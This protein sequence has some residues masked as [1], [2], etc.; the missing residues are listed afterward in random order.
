[1]SLQERAPDKE[2]AASFK[3]NYYAESTARGQWSKG[4]FG[5]DLD[6]SIV[7]GVPR[8]SG[9]KEKILRQQKGNLKAVPPTNAAS[10]Q[11]GSRLTFA[12]QPAY[13]P[14]ARQ[15]RITGSGRF[16]IQ[17]DAQGKATSVDIVQTT[18]YRILDT[19]TINTLKRWRTTAGTPS[20]IVVPITYTKPLP[21]KQPGK[22]SEP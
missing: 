1:M 6:I 12:P 10:S 3:L 16:R 4:Q 17:F 2:Y 22:K 8:I 5:I 15:N 18:G 9:I 11:T 7:D 14:E 13:P 19:A 21:V 20:T